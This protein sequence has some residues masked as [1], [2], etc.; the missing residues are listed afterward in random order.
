LA[1]TVETLLRENIFGI[2]GEHDAR[3]R[4][5]KIASLW[6]EDGVFIVPQGRYEGHSG[7]ERAAAGFI[8]R[9]PNFTFTERSEAQAF[10]G[11]GMIPWAFGPPDG[12][13]VITGIDVLVMKDD[14]IG[15]V[16]VFED[17]RKT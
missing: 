1:Q 11:V 12:D 4:R 15:A 5:A 13:P 17:S 16:Y 6:A 7:V 2:F 10:N 3:K 14:K 9:F 8:E